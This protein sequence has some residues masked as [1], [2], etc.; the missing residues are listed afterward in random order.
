ML[1]ALVVSSHQ[2]LNLV[3]K[4]KEIYVNYINISLEMYKAAIKT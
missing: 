4:T 3:L 2:V 1:C